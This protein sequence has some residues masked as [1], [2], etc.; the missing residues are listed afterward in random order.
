MKTISLSLSYDDVLLIP[1]YSK[2]HSRNDVSLESQITPKIKLTTPIIS[3]NMS[4][5]TDAKLAIAL[6]KL[7]GL[8]VLPRFD[9]IAS[10]ASQVAKVKKQNVIVGGAIGSRN[11]IIPRAQALV[12]AGVD[13]LFLDVAHGHMQ[14]AISATRKLKRMFG[15]KIDIVSGNVATFEAAKA[16]FL[17]GADS[18]KV[19]VG[20]GSICTTRIETGSGVPQITAILEASRAAKKYNKTIIADGGTK[21]SGDIVK[22]LA[23]GSCAIM[24]GSLLAGSKQSP[25]KLIKKNGLFFKQYN[26]S[27]SLAE[28]KK[29][30]RRNGKELETHY[31]KQIEGVESLVEYKGDLKDVIEKMNANIRSGFSYSG[32]KN[33]AQLWKKAQFTQITA[34]GMRESGSHDVLLVKKS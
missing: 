20:P 9:S 14:K 34:S 7:G 29:H 1:Q 26:A 11:G 17:A 27:T 33:I 16:L 13:V 19:G 22:A 30:V 25:G 12:A 31:I 15:G 10:H 24:T 28:K 4:D 5:A 6:G 32:A 8:G 21:N 18:V 2:I 23:A 3:A